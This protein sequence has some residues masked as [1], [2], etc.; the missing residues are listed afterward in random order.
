MINIQ[1]ATNNA[2]FADDKWGEV[3]R[4]LERLASGFHSGDISADKSPIFDIN[5]NRIGLIWESE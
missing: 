1:F 5:G 4:T 2:A 3:G